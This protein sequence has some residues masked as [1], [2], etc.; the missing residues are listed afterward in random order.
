MIGFTESDKQERKK[1]MDVT[2]EHRNLFCELIGSSIFM[3][4]CIRIVCGGVGEDVK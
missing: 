3:I 2:D 4:F 1:V